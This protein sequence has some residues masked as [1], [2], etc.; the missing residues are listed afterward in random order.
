MS[1]RFLP[2]LI[3]F[4]GLSACGPRTVVISGKQMSYEQGAEYYY[5][6]AQKAQLAGDTVKAKKTLKEL[7]AH[8]QKATRVP[9]A[10][11]DLGDLLFEDVG[12]P[13]AK[14][15]YRR[16]SD[17]YPASPRAR[18]ARERLAGCG[19]GGDRAAA[20]PELK[21]DEVPVEYERATTTD[22]KLKVATEVAEQRKEDGRAASAVQWHLR[23]LDNADPSQRTTILKEIES[24][25]DHG[26]SFLG[27]RQLLESKIS[28]PEVEA[29]LT[30]KL[31]KVQLHTRSPDHAKKNL[32]R[33]LKRWPS[34]PHAD[35]AEQLLKRM[36]LRESVRARTLGVLLPLSGQRA[37][38]GKNALRAVR[39]ALGMDEQD[40]VSPSGIELAVV[41]SGGNA[42]A[43]REGVRKLVYDHQAIAILGPIF[44]Q[45][46][47]AAAFA[48]QSFGVPM[49]T[50]SA[51]GEI[52]EVGP[53]IFQNG[54]TNRDQVSALVSHAME[55]K[56]MKTFAILH[57]RHPYGE[58]MLHLFWD[59][60]EKREGEIRGVESYGMTQ[61]TFIREVKALVG[62]DSPYTRKDY[63]E[64]L[65][66]CKEAADSYRRARCKE[67]LLK[68]L[69]PIVDFD[70]LFIPDYPRNI[71]LVAAAIVVEDII[72][73]NSAYALKRI[74]KTLGREVKPVTLL[75]ASGWN[76]EAIP[77]KA[78]RSVENAVFVDGFFSGSQDK[79]VQRFV[80][81]FRARHKMSPRLYPEALSFD[82]AKIAALVFRSAKPESREGFRNALLA[83]RDY[84][85]VTGTTTF[86]GET[87]ATRK[88]RVLTVQRGKIKEVAAAPTPKRR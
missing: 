42:H 84:R 70:G 66:L 48:A 47:E 19:S 2:L 54:V 14:L 13:G 26:V 23:R 82:S 68:N 9:D 33:Y 71:P 81:K 52:A 16:L 4:L 24:L 32:E 78:G 38:F 67:K 37:A 17:D 29:M 6:Q 73:E 74:E 43:A 40:Q 35:Q 69:P 15:Y 75:G 39:L 27:V 58:E 22:E 61:T 60:V 76:A 1:I 63:K 64:G 62:K 11:G 80:D 79:S 83:V 86:G 88:L 59:E 18:L 46:S 7:L 44:S 20:D 50:M 56:G 72:V 10:L 21:K 53:W 5:A 55:Q 25:V 34:G 8:F 3:L 36:D 51:G 57:P 77:E 87:R 85:G 41:D 49:L 65:R 30:F 12:C 45:E 31:A 28:E